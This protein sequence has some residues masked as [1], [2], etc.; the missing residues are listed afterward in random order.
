MK[1]LLVTGEMNS[2]GAE[3]HVYELARSLCNAGHTV[4]LASAGGRLAR[5]LGTVGVKNIRLPLN[6]KDPFSLAFSVKKLK[7]AKKNKR[8]F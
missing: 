7:R 2:G 5:E 3:T 8:L 6:C 4:T 1:I